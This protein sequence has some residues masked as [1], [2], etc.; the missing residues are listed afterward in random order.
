M[1]KILEATAKE[2]GEK[3]IAARYGGE[4]FT[5]ILPGVDEKAARQ[6]GERINDRI[7]TETF[8]HRGSETRVTVSI[9]V[10]TFP[11]N[12]ETVIDLVEAADLA[13]S[14]AKWEGK[15]RTRSFNDLKALKP[16][17]RSELQD[18]DR[19]RK[20]QRYLNEY[21]ENRRIRLY[22][23]FKTV[24]EV[25]RLE[26]KDKM[27]QLVN[28]TGELQVIPLRSDARDFVWKI[29]CDG[30]VENFVPRN[31][32]LVGAPIMSIDRKTM[33]LELRFNADLP[34]DKPS[35]VE[36]EYDFFDSFTQNVE[37]YF[38]DL[39][40]FKEPLNVTIEVKSRERNFKRWWMEP[41]AA[42]QYGTL[43]PSESLDM[44]SYIGRAVPPALRV[45]KV[46]WLW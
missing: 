37:S 18:E 9:G 39:S 44:I 10:S 29:V 46:W 17:R 13:K 12:G 45:V 16:T 25:V 26:V 38:M 40:P 27:G 35:Y 5:F 15:D 20:S 33:W 19:K 3:S 31:V 28:C 14:L 36:L 2:C 22:D 11:S 30:R 4:E 32:V 23:G 6:F 1:A 34:M 7:R 43:T 8:Q 42:N 41:Q 24:E 21:F